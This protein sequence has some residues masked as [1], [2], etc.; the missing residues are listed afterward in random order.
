MVSI[1]IILGGLKIN[2]R[3]VSFKSQYKKEIN[4]IVFHDN[5]IYIRGGKG[6]RISEDEYKIDDT[7]YKFDN[8]GELIYKT[9]LLT[10]E[11]PINSGRFETWEA[12]SMNIINNEL[13]LGYSR[14]YEAWANV[15]TGEILRG[16]FENKR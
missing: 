2:E 14:G 8:K 1:D 9:G 15:T 6:H 7:I 5:Y 13:Y 16:N 4:Q 3:Y 11:Y 10:I 12:S